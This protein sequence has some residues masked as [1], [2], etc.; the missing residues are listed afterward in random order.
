MTDANR[1]FDIKRFRKPGTFY[2]R[3]RNLFTS[4]EAYRKQLER[5]QSN[6]L[7]AAG[8]VI[9]TSLGLMID[10]E[11]FRIW[12]LRPLEYRSG[13]RGFEARVA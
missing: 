10:P 13:R 5:R 8:A 1:D 12:L 9:E 3:N 7:A 2:E 11:K 4:H 6:G